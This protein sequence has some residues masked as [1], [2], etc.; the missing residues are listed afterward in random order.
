MYVPFV[1]SETAAERS[2]E[3]LRVLASRCGV[4]GPTGWPDDGSH[5][6]LTGVRDQ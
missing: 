5:D 2:P 1:Y 3:I 4:K 6:R